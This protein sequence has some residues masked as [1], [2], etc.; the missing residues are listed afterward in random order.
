MKYLKKYNFYNVCTSKKSTVESV[1]ELIR[2]HLPFDIQVTYSG[3]TPGDIFGIYGCNK[4]IQK[5][6]VWIPKT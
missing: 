3:T 5:E 6:L 4:K 1:I 2:K